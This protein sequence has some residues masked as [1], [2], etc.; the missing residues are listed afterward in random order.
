M[1]GPN[2]ETA[3]AV[4]LRGLE[5]SGAVTIGVAYSAANNYWYRKSLLGKIANLGTVALIGVLVFTFIRWRWYIGAMGVLLLIAY[6]RAV[7][8]ASTMAARIDMLAL[9]GIF[10]LFYEN[11]AATI[12]INSSGEVLRHPTNWREALDSQA[13]GRK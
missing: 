2:S 1:G 3:E 8:W 12:R 4:R 6:V 10:D 13:E 5:Q 11:G 9:P 7:Q